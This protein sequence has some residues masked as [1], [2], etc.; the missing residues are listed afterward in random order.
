MKVRLIKGE[1]EYRVEGIPTHKKS[2]G[3]QYPKV[4]RTFS[5]MAITDEFHLVCR[6]RSWAK[7]YGHTVTSVFGKG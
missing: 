7:R 5:R 4:L 1:T 2:C 3:P 6:F